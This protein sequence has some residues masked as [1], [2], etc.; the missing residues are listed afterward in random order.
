MPTSHQVRLGDCIGRL[1]KRHGFADYRKIYDDPA[2]AGLKSSR[3][4]P[5]VLAEGD[6]VTIPDRTLKDESGQTE[7]RHRFQ[8]KTGET[9]LRIRLEDEGGAALSGR[10]YKLTV[11]TAEFEGSTP[12]DGQIE[13]P[14]DADLSA[15]TLEIW[16]KEAE[17]V[18]PLLVPLE[19]GALEHESNDRACQARLLNLNFDCGPLD[20][21]VGTRTRAALRGF[22]K[23]H[24]LTVNGNLDAA[25]RDKLRQSHE[26]A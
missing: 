14:I 15:G 22:Q 20:G 8:L 21:V 3:P 10:K 26:G 25:T 24:G 7:A 17:G 12:G 1:A 9:L 4:N 18:G 11:G 6:R 2:N 19:L 16:L 13:H 5:N 23:R